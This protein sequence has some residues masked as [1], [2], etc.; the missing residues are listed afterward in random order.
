M[1]I[2]TLYDEEHRHIMVCRLKKGDK[3]VLC[4][5][6]GIDHIGTIETIS[7]SETTIAIKQS[8]QNDTE[9]SI[10]IDLFFA[11]LTPNNTELVI[12]KCTE[13]GVSG[14]FPTTT[15]YTQGSAAKLRYDRLTKL[16]LEAA[17]QCG[18][19]KLPSINPLIK[20][21]DALKIASKYDMAILCYESEPQATI[22]NLLKNGQS[23]NAKIALFI[24]PEGGYHH[25]EIA[26]AKKAGVHI[27]T[28]GKR[29]LRAETASIVAS[30]LVTNNE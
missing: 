8:T 14:F 15:E 20:F 24:G 1:P 10:S 6:D 18:R 7:K 2:H 12:I 11:P 27:V 5:G 22:S 4:T 21:D 30:A 9:S 13:V 29:I 25:N 16:V 3:V 19:A 17:K 28:L 26:R 23:L